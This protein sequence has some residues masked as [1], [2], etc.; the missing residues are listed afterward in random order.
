MPSA[1]PYIQLSTLLAFLKSALRSDPILLKHLGS[2]GNIVRATI[3]HDPLREDKGGY[4]LLLCTQKP[5]LA[6]WKDSSDRI[7]ASGKKRMGTHKRW[8]LDTTL[9]MVYLH[10]VLSSSDGLSPAAVGER[11]SNLVEWQM[12][13]YIEAHKMDNSGTVFDLLDEGNI[14]SVSMGEA[15]AITA[16]KGGE[17]YDGFAA[18]INM[19]HY[20]APYEEVSP[21]ALKLIDLELHLDDVV[22]AVDGPIIEGEIDLT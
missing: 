16:T 10:K 6:I 17:N 9:R 22:P 14:E 21:M 3:E 4:P 11:I 5:V 15:T 7:R 12:R 2:P 19:I 8:G 13:G 18:E 20:N 1:P